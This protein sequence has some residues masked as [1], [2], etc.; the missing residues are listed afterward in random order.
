[1]SGTRG[2]GRTDSKRAPG[3]FGSDGSSLYYDGGGSYMT[4]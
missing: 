2:V 3:N 1:L 4:M